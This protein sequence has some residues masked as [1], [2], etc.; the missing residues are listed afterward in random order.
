M[1]GLLP[2]LVLDT[3]LTMS[4]AALPGSAREW[5]LH[6]V[7]ALLLNLDREVSF[8]IH[9][10]REV[11]RLIWG[12]RLRRNTQL[13]CSSTITVMHPLNKLLK[14]K[15]RVELGGLTSFLLH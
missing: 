14:L 11:V 10:Q 5:L 8:K 7:S 1:H 3:F 6:K 12:F 13:G 9:R 15:P 4:K 2:A